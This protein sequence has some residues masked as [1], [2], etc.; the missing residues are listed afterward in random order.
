MDPRLKHS[1][2]TFLMRK[3]KVFYNKVFAGTLEESDSG[4]I[5]TYDEN[6]LNQKNA[7]PV[8]LTL[9]LRREAYL[10]KELFPFFEGL[11]PE[12]WLFELNSRLL[13]IDSKDDFGMLLATGMDCI[14]AV[15]VIREENI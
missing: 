5:F 9:P 11:I 12:G 10:S 1:G 4:Y 7:A 15:S 8:S 14:G 13:K 3:A 2:M 6:Y